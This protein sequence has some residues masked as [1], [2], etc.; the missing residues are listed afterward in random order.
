MVVM[1]YHVRLYHAISRGV[2]SLV[3]WLS[4]SQMLH[5]VLHVTELIPINAKQKTAQRRSF[6]QAVGVPVPTSHFSPV[7]STR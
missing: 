1:Q 2:V 4:I 3:N 6:V 5:G 7:F